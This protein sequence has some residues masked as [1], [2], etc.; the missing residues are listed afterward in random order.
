LI[1]P[2]K[3]MIKYFINRTMYHV[4]LVTNA[5]D[6]IAAGYPELSSVAKYACGHDESKF[7]FPELIPYVWLTWRHKCKD[8]GIKFDYPEGV[9]DDVFRATTHHIISNPHHPEYHDSDAIGH[10]KDT[11]D[12]P[13][14]AF[15]MSNMDIAEMVCDWAA[16]SREQGSGLKDWFDQN[17]DV[18]W[19]FGKDQIELI[20]SL[21]GVLGPWVQNG[22]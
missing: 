17:L 2:N 11:V 9:E 18:R 22:Y 20:N 5:A 8:E 13:V 15:K 7:S 6:I 14:E 4:K 10:E 1:E 16:M 19:K 12:R 3:E 21:I